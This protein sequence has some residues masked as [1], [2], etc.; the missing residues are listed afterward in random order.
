MPRVEF[1]VIFAGWQVPW[2]YLL[3]SRAVKCQDLPVSRAIYNAA[4]SAI[5]IAGIIP[6]SNAICNAVS[7]AIF[8]AGIIHL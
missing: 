3:V 7:S 8:I 6:D 5:F 2:R 4:S 1:H